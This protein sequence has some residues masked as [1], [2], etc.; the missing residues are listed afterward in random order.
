MRPGGNMSEANQPSER[1]GRLGLIAL[2][3]ASAAVFAVLVSLGAWQMQRLAWKEDILAR[4]AARL[5]ADPVPL[6]PP[7]DWVRL[8]ATDYE[9]TPVRV[10]GS[11]RHDLEMLIFRPAGGPQKQP[12]YHVITPLKVAGGEAYVMVNRGFVPEEFRDPARRPAGQAA[13]EV[14]VTGLLRA[15]ETRTSF[16]PADEPGKRLW[17]TRD[18]VAM[19]R[20]AGLSGAAPFSIDANDAPNPGG[21]PKGGVTVVSIPNDHLGYA[22]TWFGL[23]ATLVVMVVLVI[24]RRR[25]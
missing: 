1:R 11:F 17:Y 12:G 3:I 10:T 21:W 2:L 13:G 5:T 23:A 9:Y 24:W 16:T 19:A 7:V 4:M 6:P 8:A 22:M 15:P 14:A 18:P 25:V 20:Q